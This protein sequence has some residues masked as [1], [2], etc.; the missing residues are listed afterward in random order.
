METV[1]ELLRTV[2]SVVRGKDDQIVLAATCL[3]A[4]GHL[5]I[6]DLP[7]LGK[8]ILARSLAASIGGEFRRI[9]FTP[10]LLPS[11]LTGVT[12]YHQSQERFAFHPGPVFANVVLADE[13]NRASPKTQ[14]AM[15]EV[16]EEWRVTVDGV[17]HPV[18]RPFMVVATQ[19]PI[20]L[21]GTYR[22]PEA[23]LDRFL[24][25]ISMGYPDAD[26]ELEVLRNHGGEPSLGQVRP[27]MSGEQIQH[28]IDR[29]EATHMADVVYDYVLRL[30]GATRNMAELRVGVSTR[31]ALALAR[32]A[33]ALAV[34]IDRDYVTP[35]EVKRLAVPVL[36]H[37]VVLTPEAELQGHTGE[38]L[39]ESVLATVPTPKTSST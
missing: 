2:G 9:Q 33:R 20:E 16:M 17:T 30:C 3:V 7:G 34:I 31:G 15:L 14:A 23:Q 35:D 4:E 12:V 29:A 1:P 6:E 11:D 21:E 8:T 27:V 38:S 37:R 36:A 39:V 32:A 22:L 24:M 18:P 26:A 25:R 19:N 28:F 13:V 10:D 5:L